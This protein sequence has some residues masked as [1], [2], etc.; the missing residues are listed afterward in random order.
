MVAA[1][2]PGDYHRP[3]RSVVILLT[4]FGP[5]PA[6]L[7][8]FLAS[9]RANPSVVW[10]VHHDAAPPA[11]PPPNVRFFPTTFAAY[12]A[13]IAAHLD[14][15][16]APPRPYKLCDVKPMLGS[17]HEAEIR[18]FDTWGFGDLDVIYGDLRAHYDDAVLAHGVVSSHV[19]MV[20]GHLA[21]FRNDARYREAFRQI[22]AWQAF[23][24]WPGSLRFDEDVLTYAFLDAAARRRR[25][26]RRV[27]AGVP[28]AWLL[29]ELPIVGAPID[30]RLA[31]GVL[32]QERYSTI[33]TPYPWHD[34]Q[35]T[36]PDTW[37]WERGRLTNARD[38][39]RDF[40]YLHFMNYLSARH[41]RAGETAPWNGLEPLVHFDPRRVD[42]GRIRIDRAGFHLEPRGGSPT[43]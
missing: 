2:D 6:W 34:G 21:L 9:C 28:R 42:E 1:P 3:V 4:W 35:P 36:H 27:R 13:R 15:P 29:R 33:H 26:E 16:F 17:I 8:V 23:V 25:F 20:S 18:G 19:G 24:T 5:W 12:A 22:P 43:R 38:G 7:P 11:E 31:E 30:P 37:Y 40:L 41:V 39:E 10:H 32:M 14:A